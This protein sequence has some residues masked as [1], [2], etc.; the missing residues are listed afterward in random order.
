MR[1]RSR[2]NPVTTFTTE[3]ALWLAGGGVVIA[4]T[5]GWMLYQAGKS[6]QQ[7]ADLQAAPA[8]NSDTTTY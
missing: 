8:A 2:R 1:R 4:G 7:I 6:A 3:Q 5:L